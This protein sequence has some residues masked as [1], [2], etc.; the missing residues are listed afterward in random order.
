MGDELMNGNPRDISN[1]LYAFGTCTTCTVRLDKAKFRNAFAFVF[2][3][4][5]SA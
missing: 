2:I 5:D 1:L 4:S 3:A